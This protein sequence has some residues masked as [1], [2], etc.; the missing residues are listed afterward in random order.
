ML[1]KLLLTDAIFLTWFVWLCA[2]A[3]GPWHD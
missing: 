1:L 2:N 3:P